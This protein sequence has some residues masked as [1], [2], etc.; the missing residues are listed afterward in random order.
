[1]PA[2]TTPAQ[3]I[4]GAWVVIAD[5]LEHDP[6]MRVPFAPVRPRASITPWWE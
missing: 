6:A 5:H 4:C 1:M 3:V 2:P